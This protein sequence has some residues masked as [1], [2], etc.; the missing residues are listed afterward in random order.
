M[1]AFANDPLGL[2]TALLA[3]PALPTTLETAPVELS[4]LQRMWRGKCPI[5]LPWPTPPC[6][7]EAV[8]LP[9][10]PW[11][12][13]IP[14]EVDLTTPA[15]AATAPESLHQLRRAGLPPTATLAAAPSVSAPA[16]RAAPAA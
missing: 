4:R 3:L 7:F 12:V 10:P 11:T 14:A 16:P 8:S 6:R 15:P 9:A 1:R 13:A 2:I 5:F